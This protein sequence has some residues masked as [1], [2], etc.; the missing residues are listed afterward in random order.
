[1]ILVEPLLLQEFG[2]GVDVDEVDDGEDVLGFSA[3]DAFAIGEEL[4]AF[5][6][7]VVSELIGGWSTFSKGEKASPGVWV[8][9]KNRVCLRRYCIIIIFEESVDR[10]YKIDV[11]LIIN[12][13]GLYTVLNVYL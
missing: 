13:L 10:L 8:L 11:S 2:D 1:M 7:D 9:L 4:A 3:R 6:V 12:L 5:V